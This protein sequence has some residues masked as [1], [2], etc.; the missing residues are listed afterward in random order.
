MESVTI[1]ATSAIELAKLGLQIY[2]ASAQQANLTD[3][4]MTKLLEG[5]R[6]RFQEN[7]K[8]ELPDV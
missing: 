2:F 4:Q 7:I 8:Q 5:E 3:E 1:I 6:T